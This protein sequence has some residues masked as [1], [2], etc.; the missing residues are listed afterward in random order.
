MRTPER[1]TAEEEAELGRAV[2]VGAPAECPRCQGRLDEWAIPPR[3][4]VSYVRDRVWLVCPTCR[5][6]AVLDRRGPR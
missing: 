6:T 3:G 2:R 4:D 5:R 1:F